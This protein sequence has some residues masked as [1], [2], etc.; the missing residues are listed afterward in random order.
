MRKF[1][2]A[3]ARFFAALCAVL[4]AVTL[5]IAL[6][7]VRAEDRLF[8][9]ETY[10]RALE[11]TNT[12]GRLP[13]LVAQQ[14]MANL[15]ADPCQERPLTCL[16]PEATPLRTC[17][18]DS[19]G[20]DAFLALSSDERPATE[21][22][23]AAIQSCINK[24]GPLP[25]ASP[26]RQSG[27]PGYLKY[28]TVK[29]WETLITTLVTPQQ[30]R[31]IAE[32]TLDGVF[33]YLDGKSDTVSVSLLPI[34]K[35]LARNSTEA[36]K[37]ILA[38]QPD[39]TLEQLAIMT[40]QF[41]NPSQGS[42]LVL[43]NPPKE[44]LTTVEP[45][46]GGLFQAQIAALPDSVPVFTKEQGKDILPR[47]DLARLIMRLSPLAPLAFLLLMTLLAVR[48]RAGWL[49]WWGLALAGAGALGLLAGLLIE[50]VTR[51]ILTTQTS[52]MPAYTAHFVE[53]SLD[54]ILVVV[55]EVANPLMLESALAL[56][57]GLV[58]LVIAKKYFGKGAA[59]A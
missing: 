35:D 38:A 41:I 5:V 31:Q 22:E 57:A 30:M 37:Q 24:F 15:S 29:D 9:A 12:Y 14:L 13:A 34:K 32:Q 10:K 23:Q 8:K 54:V 55:R 40:L 44:V 26:N 56:A 46:I 4:F 21:A 49:R 43:C 53:A 18:Q 59:G 17:M 27:A 2:T 50:P 7:L 6:I 33:A 45:L 48:S 42:Q 11:T 16:P 36:V 51:I 1:L 47:I 39:C 19:L 52:Q 3:L 58:M 20:A 25:P 28:L